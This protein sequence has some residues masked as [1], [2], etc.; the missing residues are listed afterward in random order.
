MVAKKL[1][2]DFAKAVVGFSF[3]KHTRPIYAGI[4]LSKLYEDDVQSV[5]Q[6]KIGHSRSQKRHYQARIIRKTNGIAQK[7]D[8]FLQGFIY[9]R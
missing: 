7:M 6:S 5:N 4:V 1:G 2:F 9:E 8:V 3:G